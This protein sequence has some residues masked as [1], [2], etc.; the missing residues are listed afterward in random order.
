MSPP[1]FSPQSHRDIAY[2][3]NPEGFSACCLYENIVIYALKP[4]PNPKE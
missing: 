1:L 4:N 3:P 2:M